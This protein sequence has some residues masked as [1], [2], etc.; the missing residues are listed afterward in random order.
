MSKHE[1]LQEDRGIPN[2]LD[3][4]PFE[5][6]SGLGISTFTYDQSIEQINK[7]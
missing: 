7:I 5:K 2:V 4:F 6:F 3:K 1:L